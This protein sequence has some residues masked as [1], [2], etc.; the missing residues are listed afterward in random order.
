MKKKIPDISSLA[1]KT[2]CNTK[3]VE[4]DTKV[5]NL[6]GKIAK[7]KNELI[8]NIKEGREFGVLSLFMGNAIFDG[9]DGFQA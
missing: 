3:N 4:I 9:V 6:D 1:K 7:N 2:D 5:S 8:K